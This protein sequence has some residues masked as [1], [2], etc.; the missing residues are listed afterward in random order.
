[1]L[2]FAV[3]ICDA[4]SLSVATKQLL[5]RDARANRAKAASA[6]VDVF[7]SLC[8]ADEALLKAKGAAIYAHFGNVVTANVPLA[9]I[10][11]IAALPGVRQVAVAESGCADTDE[12]R[13]ATDAQIAQEGTSY[14]LPKNYTGKNVVVGIIDAGID[15]NHA[16]FADEKGNTRIRRVYAGQ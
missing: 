4:Q 5:N 12:S 3:A 13:I 1:M 10:P 14:A 15:F 11:D 6:S 16:A 9:A 8:G 7:I 2:C